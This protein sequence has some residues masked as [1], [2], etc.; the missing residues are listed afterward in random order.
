MHAKVYVIADKFG[1]QDLKELAR[2]KFKDELL[3]DQVD[4][5]AYVVECEV[6]ISF[7]LNHF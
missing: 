4:T 5:F 1:V 7:L 2:E 3:E 6:P